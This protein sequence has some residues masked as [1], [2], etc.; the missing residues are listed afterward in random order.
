MSKH[1]QGAYNISKALSTDVNVA[2]KFSLVRNFT[3]DIS[4]DQSVESSSFFAVVGLIKGYT[5][6]FIKRTFKTSII[7]NSF[8]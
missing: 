8:M 7:V 6:K 5:V 3:S 1:L 2:L 4:D